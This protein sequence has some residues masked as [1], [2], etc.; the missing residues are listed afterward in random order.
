MID[1][2]LFEK[3]NFTFSYQDQILNNYYQIKFLKYQQKLDS[4]LFSILFLNF[5][6]GITINYI[7]FSNLVFYIPNLFFIIFSIPIFVFLIKNKGNFIFKSILRYLLII[8]FYSLIIYEIIHLNIYISD[9]TKFIKILKSCYRLILISSITIC[10]LIEMNLISML[11]S[12]TINT[13]ILLIIQIG[14]SN[15]NLIFI[16]EI[17]GNILIFLTFGFIRSLFEYHF[18][19][20]FEKKIKNNFINSNSK[21]ILQ[22]INIGFL[23]IS[24]NQLI[25]CNDFFIN[26]INPICNSFQD[27]GKIKINKLLDTEQKLINEELNHIRG[28]IHI[29]SVEEKQQ[30]SNNQQ[31]KLSNLIGNQF[32]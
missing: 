20:Y 6:Y 26:I 19:F 24:N 10:F 21:S 11:V 25:F 23:S 2:K 27:D 14:F 12:G 18:K 16:D 32:N 15:D 9:S 30:E 31:N 7:S 13:A 8:F 1:D 3:H 5:I 22:D 17:L 4:I 28:K 29:Y